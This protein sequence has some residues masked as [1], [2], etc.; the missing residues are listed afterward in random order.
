VFCFGEN[1]IQKLKRNVLSKFI[2]FNCVRQK[3]LNSKIISFFF[4]IIIL[5]VEGYQL[6]PGKFSLKQFYSKYEVV[7]IVLK[8]S[9]FVLQGMNKN[10]K[11]NSEKFFVTKK[12]LSE[13]LIYYKYF[14]LIIFEKRVKFSFLD[15]LKSSLYFNYLIY[16]IF[17]FLDFYL[18]EKEKLKLKEKELELDNEFIYSVPVLHNS[19]DSISYYRYFIYNSVNFNLIRRCAKED[20]PLYLFCLN[21]VN[22]SYLNDMEFSKLL[23][24]IR[25]FFRKLNKKQKAYNVLNTLVKKATPLSKIIYQRRGRIF[26]PLTN[27]I[28]NQNIRTSLGMKQIYMKSYQLVNLPTNKNSFNFKLFITL[29][30]ILMCNNFV[31][32]S[33]ISTDIRKESYTKGYFLKTLKA[34]HGKI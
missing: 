4:N 22:F 27:V 25:K 33:E 11:I 3:L 19:M 31:Y 7:F 10:F 9:Y 24:S 12:S 21:R 30:D 6:L 5:S 16:S 13:F 28:Y 23:S 15:K 17:H 14:L 26:I 2:K 20:V 29:L 1:R 32:Q 34:R 8:F 18:G